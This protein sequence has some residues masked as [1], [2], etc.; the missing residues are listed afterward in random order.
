MFDKLPKGYL[1]K[2]L[3]IIRNELNNFNRNAGLIE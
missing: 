3:K 2:M 1:S